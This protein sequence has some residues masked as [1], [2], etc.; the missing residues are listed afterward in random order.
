MTK[1]AARVGDASTP[2]HAPGTLTPGPGS[3][4]VSIGNKPAWR[5]N[6]DTAAC[7][8]PIAPP[9]P[10]PHGPEKCYLGSLSVMINNQMAVRQGDILIGAGPPNP[11][12]L[13]FPTVL[14]GDVGFGLMDPANMSEFC[15]EFTQLMNDWATLTPEQRRARL[16]DAINRQLGKSG[17]PRQSVVGNASHAPGNAQYSYQS[18]ALEVSQSQLNSASLSPQGARQLA[19]AVYHEAR[20]AEQ[21]HLMA[22]LAAGRGQSAAQIQSST[23]MTPATAQAAAANPL[24]GTSAQSNLANASYDSVYGPRGAYRNGV[25]NDIQNRYSEYRALPEEQDAWNTGDTL[26]CG[27]P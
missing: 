5:A 27:A 21:W 23:F 18:G 12:L 2:P 16:E 25:L 4:D 24:T 3:V 22:R 9:A 8:T 11:V 1:P 6:I 20:H 10:A 17:L 13:G 19:N 7:T 26:P 15:K 14:I